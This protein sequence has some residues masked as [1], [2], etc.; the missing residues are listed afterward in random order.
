M[1]SAGKYVDIVLC[2]NM[3]TQIANQITNTLYMNER[4]VYM[5]LHIVTLWTNIYK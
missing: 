5:Y 3:S 1:R 4:Q 2:M